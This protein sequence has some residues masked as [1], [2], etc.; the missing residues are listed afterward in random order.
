MSYLPNFIPA[1]VTV[2]AVKNILSGTHSNDVVAGEIKSV[3]ARMDDGDLRLPELRRSI[4]L[5]HS[6]TSIIKAAKAAVKRPETQAR[7]L[8]KTQVGAVRN[9]WMS[10]QVVGATWEGCMYFSAANFDFYKVEVTVLGV[11]TVTG[12]L[13]DTAQPER[14]IERF[15][16][17]D[18]FLAAYMF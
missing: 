17:F 18:S 5:G 4:R 10:A 11:V 16:S 9:A 7:I 15:R 3:V 1:L 14:A 12:L 6:N 13:R 8:N 2:D